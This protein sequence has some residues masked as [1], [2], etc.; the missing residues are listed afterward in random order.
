[1]QDCCSVRRG[2]SQT[3]VENS[4]G[5]LGE[6][7]LKIGYKIEQETKDLGQE[8]ILNIEISCAATTLL[9]AHQ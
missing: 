5:G 9:M 4:T 3:R 1:V 6:F 8:Q 2:N 7:G